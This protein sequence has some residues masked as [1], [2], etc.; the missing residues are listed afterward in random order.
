MNELGMKPTISYRN[1]DYWRL[2][3]RFLMAG[4]LPRGVVLPRMINPVLQFRSTEQTVSMLR[5]ARKQK[6]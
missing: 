5:R 2:L 6:H 4:L 3:P 1:I